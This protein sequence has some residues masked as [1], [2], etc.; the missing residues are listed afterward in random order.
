VNSGFKK[1]ENQGDRVNQRQ[2]AEVLLAY[3]SSCLVVGTGLDGKSYFE[4]KE[5]KIE[6]NLPQDYDIYHHGRYVAVAEVKCRHRDMY[7]L[8]FFKKRDVLIKRKTMVRLYREHYK[9]GRHVLIVMRTSDKHIVYA[10]MQDL[11]VDPD[12]MKKAPD[13][14]CKDDHGKK[15]SDDAGMI[16]PFSAFTEIP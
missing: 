3:I 15:D 7:T 11:L 2:V 16:L 8:D 1:F 12:L 5:T 13:G 10:T 6:L 9:L 14:Y 4:F